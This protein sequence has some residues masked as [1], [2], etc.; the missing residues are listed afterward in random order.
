MRP[1]MDKAGANSPA[2]TVLFSLHVEH[3]VGIR[4]FDTEAEK[5]A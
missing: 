5:D 4:S 1:I 3:I 2:H